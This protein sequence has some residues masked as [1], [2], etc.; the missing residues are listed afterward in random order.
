MRRAR[1]MPPTETVT[2]GTAKTS[3]LVCAVTVAI[4][5]LSRTEIGFKALS[6]LAMI[7]LLVVLIGL[8]ISIYVNTAYSYQRTKDTLSGKPERFLGG[9]RL[10]PEATKIALEKG[11]GPQALFENCNEKANLVWT[12]ESQAALQ[13]VSTM[14]FILLQVSGSLALA[15]ASML[16]SLSATNAR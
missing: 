6:I 7:L 14:G 1:W 15:T 11:L 5:Y 16:V 13:V 8:A 12:Q 2:G 9:F 3:A 10:T 4:L